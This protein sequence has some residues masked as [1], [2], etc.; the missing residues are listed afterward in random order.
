MKGRVARFS[1]SASVVLLHPTSSSS[2]III[3]S[4]L[5]FS[6]PLDSNHAYTPAGRRFR[7]CTPT[8]TSLDEHFVGCA[9][10]QSLLQTGEWFYWWSRQGAG[11]YRELQCT[12]SNEKVR[13]RANDKRRVIDPS[14]DDNSTRR[15]REANLSGVESWH[16]LCSFVNFV[17]L[18]RVWWGHGFE[19]KINFI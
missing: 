18:W 19:I 14:H 10:V 8:C 2:L 16:V 1:K 15:E 17:R 3:Y 4:C 11:E 5:Q 13:C 9:V 6:Q 12:G 7:V